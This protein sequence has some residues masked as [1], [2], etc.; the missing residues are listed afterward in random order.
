MIASARNWARIWPRVAPRAAQPEL[1]A[2]FQD[3]DD[4]DV[5]DA[6]RADQEGDGAEAEEQG[7]ERALGLG[8]GGEGVRGAGDVDLAGVFRAGLGAELVVDADDGGLGVGGADVDLRRVPVEAQVLLGAGEAD[9]DGGVDLGG[10]GVGVENAG[11]VEPLAGGAAGADPDPHAGP[12]PVDAQQPGCGGAEHGD[13]LAGGS[14]S[15]PPLWSRTGW[16]G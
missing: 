9:Q 11:D 6:D 14:G 7:V 2:A 12:D 13:G 3:G 16:K 1:G 15:P 4:H 8:P 5:G 10:V